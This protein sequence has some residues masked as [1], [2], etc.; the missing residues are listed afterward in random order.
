MLNIAETILIQIKYEE[1]DLFIPID[2]N[3]KS[4]K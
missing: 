3:K 2:E 4:G 1:I